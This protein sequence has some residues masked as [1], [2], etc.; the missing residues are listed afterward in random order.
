MGKAKIQLRGKAI[1]NLARHAVFHQRP[2]DR[3]SFAQQRMAEATQKNS[4]SYVAYG[5]EMDD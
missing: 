3:Q 4:I 1:V 5:V 2:A